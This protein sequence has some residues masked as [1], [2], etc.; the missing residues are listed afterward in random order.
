MINPRIAA[1]SLI[2]L[3]ALLSACAQQPGIRSEERFQG[4]G[5]S[6]LPPPGDNWALVQKSPTVLGFSKRSAEIAAPYQSVVAM[7]AVIPSTYGYPGNA[8]D[9]P[10]AF[11]TF[12]EDTL[13]DNR[14]TLL[15]VKVAP[16]GTQGEY[17]AGFEFIQE[18]RENRFAPNLILEIFA[19][20]Y[21]CLDESKEFLVQVDY[22][23]RK[24]G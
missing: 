8:A 3:T 2:S 18:E 17:C 5:Y 20:G 19:N 6:A 4:V 24:R 23:V 15:G 11:K 7:V 12:Y 21:I 14:H 22:S 13:T 1:L 10:A 9:F 16:F